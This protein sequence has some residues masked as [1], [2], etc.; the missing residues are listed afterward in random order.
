MGLPTSKQINQDY[1]TFEA[2]AYNAVLKGMNLDIYQE[3]QSDMRYQG[4]E[5]SYDIDGETF[6]EKFLRVSTNE[7]ANFYNRVSSL[8][9]RNLS[10]TDVI[11]W[12][13]NPGAE[14]NLTVDKYKREE[15]NV[16]TKSG[17]AK[18]GI[19]GKVDALVINGENMIG[20]P[21]ILNLKLN[22]K[23]Y[24]RVENTTPVPKARPKPNSAVPAGA[25][26]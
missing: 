12:Q 14:K 13:L 21:C 24:P 22:D 2:G 7:R 5:L 8:L 15:G 23:G 18:D 25:P 19:R 6:V 11:E 17:E 9:G 20:K 3:Y 4:V 26:S 1:A 16:F 10:E